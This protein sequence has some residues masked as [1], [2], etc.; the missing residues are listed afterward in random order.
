MDI[1][2]VKNLAML[3]ELATVELRTS[4]S[5]LSKACQSVCAFLNAKGG[6]MLN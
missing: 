3:G 2:Q 6:S 5:E 4:T 1:N